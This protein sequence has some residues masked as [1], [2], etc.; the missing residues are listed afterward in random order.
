MMMIDLSDT[1]ICSAIETHWVV[2]DQSPTH[3]DHLHRWSHVLSMIDGMRNLVRY[4]LEVNSDSEIKQMLDVLW[5][6]GVKRQSS[7]RS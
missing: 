4:G 3:Q 7:W 2:A 6:V 1:A 5:M